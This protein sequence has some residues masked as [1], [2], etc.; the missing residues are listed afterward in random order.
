M[1]GICGELRFDGRPVD[2]AELVAMRD[3]LVHRGPDSLG[4]YRSSRGHAG[5]GFRRL[6]IIDLSPNAGQPMPNEDGTVHVVFNGEI[7]NYRSLREELVAHGHRFRSHSDTEV[8]VHLYEE[9]G[10]DAIADLE[11]MFAIAIWDDRAERLTL[12]RDRAGK[13]PLFYYRDHRLLAFASEMKSF[14]T[15]PDIAIEPD[16]EAVPYYFIYGYVPQPATIYK[17]VSQVAP[18]TLMTVEA[19]GRTATRRYWQLRFPEAGQAQPIAHAEA[20]AGVRERLTR[21]VERRLESDVPLGAFL[22][23]GVDSTI[24]V[25]LMSRMMSAP[26]KTFSIGFEG[27]PAFDETAYARMVAERFHTDH[28]EFRVSPSAIELVDTLVWHHDGPFGDSSAVPTYLVSKL[29]REHVTV[30]LTGDG[31]DELFA[32]YLR[33]YAALL[34]ERIPAAAGRAANGT[35]GALPQPPNE[36][37]WLARAQRFFRSMGLPLH[38]RVT[39]W[40]SLFF[41][42]HGA[43]L[44]SGLRARPRA[45]RQA[46]ASSCGRSGSADRP[47]R[48]QPAAVRELHVVSGRRSPRENRPLHHGEFDRG[49]RAVSGSRADRVRRHVARLAEAGRAADESHPARRVSRLAAAGDRRAR[50]DGI[51][52]AARR[53]VPRRAAGLRARP[54]AVAG[55]P[56]SRVAVAGVR[57]SARVPTSGRSRQPRAAALV[58]RDVRS[59][60]ATAAGVDQALMLDFLK[61]NL[62]PGH[63]AA[64]LMLLTPGTV[65]LFVPALARWGRR[66]LAALA[67]FYLAV[68]CPLGAGLLA[69]TLTYGYRPIASADEARGAQAIVLL[70]SGSVNL[71]ASGRQLS[72]VTMDAGLRAL[73]TARLFDLLHG[74]LVIASGGVTEHDAAA[75]PESAALQ[76]ALLDLGVRPDRIL[77]E[78]RSKNTRDE[79][80]IIKDMLSARGL[81]TFV[82]VTSPLHMRRSM[83]TFEREGLHPI[84][85]PSPLVP[86]RSTPRNPLLPSD[87]WLNVAD[88][89]LYEWMAR[90]Y[91]WWKGWLP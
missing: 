40:N 50:Q 34:A 80:V 74:P 27:D 72:S 37:H 56:P 65:M 12:A 18:G 8:I 68:S 76:H 91:Y 81:T 47:V 42:D 15:H 2:E 23:G 52:R 60:A 29:T 45:D 4:A 63:M 30:V 58:D 51:R 22:S 32:G 31:G 64:A 28:T 83:M 33:F 44:R 49:A 9:K 69:R 86:E 57:R 66:W 20:A 75:A 67:V 3:R 39:R 77:L 10:A 53:L 35:L 71:R 70:G 41:D 14:F 89:V 13:K 78:S 85:S 87:L 82:L 21:A 7:Y 6:K 43:L 62:R 11:G 84:P 26:V 73:E 19:D 88:G 48:P 90:A 55:C 16:P 38:D 1:C 79:A 36:R 46:A 5:L 61:E 24:V 17:R 54:A 59:V 25:G